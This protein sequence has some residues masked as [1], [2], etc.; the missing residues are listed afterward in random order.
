MKR[1]LTLCAFGAAMALLAAC[2]STAPP[3]AASSANTGEE[4]TQEIA[5]TEQ[6]ICRNIIKTGTRLGTRVCKTEAQWQQESQGSRDAVNA[7]QNNSAQS[8]GPG[9]G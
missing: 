7:I 2:S 4:M 3:Q 5:S 8:A 6:L 9:G 1:S